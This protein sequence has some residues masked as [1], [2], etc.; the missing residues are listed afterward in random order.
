MCWWDYSADTSCEKYMRNEFG[1]IIFKMQ[2]TSLD[3]CQNEVH[4]T[5]L[6]AMCAGT[7]SIVMATALTEKGSG[8][9]LKSEHGSH[10]QSCDHRINFF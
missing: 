8:V 4:W 3:A 7:Q 10:D 9:L 5:S 2:T 6:L 1:E